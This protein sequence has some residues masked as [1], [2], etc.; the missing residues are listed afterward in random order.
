VQDYCLCHVKYVV[1]TAQVSITLCSSLL[2]SALLCSFLLFST[3][4]CSSLLL[5]APLYTP[6]VPNKWSSEEQ[7]DRD[8][9]KYAEIE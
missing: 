9:Q 6:L 4:L 1:K 2:L 7:R 5:S 8:E 3:S